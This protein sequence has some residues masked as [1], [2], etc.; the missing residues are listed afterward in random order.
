MALG[1]YTITNIFY[2]SLVSTGPPHHLTSPHHGPCPRQTGE[3]LARHVLAA[4]GP[5]SG[6][7]VAKGRD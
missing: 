4:H 5:P 3:A 6:H 2:S 7:H 1:P